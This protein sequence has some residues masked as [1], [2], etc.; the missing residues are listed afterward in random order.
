MGDKKEFQDKPDRDR[1]DL[2]RPGDTGR[3]NRD[4]G[5]PPGT[6]KIK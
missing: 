4:K 6:K 3:T 1:P 2:N 5:A